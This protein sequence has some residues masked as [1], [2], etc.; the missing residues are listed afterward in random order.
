MHFFSILRLVRENTVG[1]IKHKNYIFIGLYFANY[2]VFKRP[3]L[4]LS[5][6][7]WIMKDI[8]RSGLR[9]K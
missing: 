7:T 4:K 2:V 3:K 6:M 5:R 1:K 8:F 9:V